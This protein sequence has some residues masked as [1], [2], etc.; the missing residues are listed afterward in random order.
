MAAHMAYGHSPA[1]DQI[2]AAAAAYTKDTAAPDLSHI[3]H[4]HKS[5]W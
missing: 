2:G 3:C 1:R 4:L 5:L